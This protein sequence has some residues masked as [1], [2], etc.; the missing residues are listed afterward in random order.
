MCGATGVLDSRLVELNQRTDKLLLDLAQRAESLEVHVGRVEGEVHGERAERCAAVA[1]LTNQSAEHVQAAKELDLKLSGMCKEMG[2]SAG[3]RARS[4]E[5]SLERLQ[6]DKADNAA[7]LKVSACAR[8]MVPGRFVLV[9]LGF[10]VGC[11]LDAPVH[12]VDRNPF[13]LLMAKNTVGTVEIQNCVFV[14]VDRKRCSFGFCKHTRVTC[15]F[16]C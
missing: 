4:M 5:A 2:D 16:H 1:A 8:R 10:S 9:E 12:P 6:Q 7:F 3:E 14:C 15:V 11:D 13:P